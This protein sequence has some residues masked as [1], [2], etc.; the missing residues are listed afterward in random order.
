MLK[1]FNPLKK[2][3]EV[4][5]IVMKDLKRKYY[6]FRYARYYGGIATAD[7]VGCSFLCAYCWNYFR[8]LNP[9]RFGK[10]YSP[11]EASEKIMEIVN[12]KNIEKVR[13]SGAEPILGKKSFKHLIRLIEL[14]LNQKS[15][16]TFILETNG[17]I[18]GLNK[19]F[20]KK[21]SKF[22]VWVR[23]SIKGWN[24][25]SFEKISNAER[26]FF[27]YPLKAIK[28]LQDYGID[29]WPAIMYEIFGS[30]GI[31]AIK[32]K[33]KEFGI[34]GELEIEYIEKYP[35]VMKNLAKRKIK[36]KF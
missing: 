21:L 30:D 31:K 32:Q 7:T 22:P 27:I 35:F 3:E 26:C 6:R 25:N 4:E 33:M 18:L 15:K 14:L 17:L 8:N 16:L 10:F 28:Y 11:K 23:V 36:L 12:R 2:A 13:V 24:E 20:C 9:E 5:R 29:A 34:E 1:Y 19:L